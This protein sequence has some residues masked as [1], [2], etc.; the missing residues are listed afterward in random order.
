VQEVETVLRYHELSKHGSPGYAP[1]PGYLDW[2]NQ[3]DPFRR[4]HGAALLPLEQE[5][6]G[7][8]PLYE[9]AFLLG[10][11]P[12]SPVTLRSVSRLF[13][14]SLALSAWKQAGGSRW[15][16]RVNPSSGNLHP[17]EAYLVSGPIPGLLD[18]AAVCH[19]APREHALEVR[20]VLPEG[21]WE[22]I[23]A[24]LPPEALLVGLTS[25]HW[26]EAWKYGLRAYRYCQHDAGHALGAV[27]VAAAG[28][29]YEAR[30]LDGLGTA[31]IETLLGVTGHIGPESEEGDCLLAIVSAGSGPIREPTREAVAAFRG[32]AWRGTPNRLSPQHVDWGITGAAWAARKPPGHVPAEPPPDFPRL[33]VERSPLSLRRIIHQRRSAVAMDG[34]TGITAAAFYQILRKTLPGPDQVP[35]TTLP[36]AP[37][38]HLALFVHRVQGLDPG[39]YLLARDPAAVQSL[40]A[41]LP[42]DF[43]WVRPE[44]SPGAL[45]LFHLSTGDLRG[46]AS[47]LSCNQDIAGDGCFA[48]AMLAEFAGPVR[49]GAWWYPRLF[50]ECG[51][52]GQVLYLEAEASGISA[53]GIGCYF[54]DPTHAVLGLRDRTYQSLYHFT[55]GGRVDDPR[56]STLPAYENP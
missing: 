14:D 48:V 34:R 9:P 33:H 4:Y 20:A 27:A 31:R 40:R 1:G 26:R 29:G 12:P 24:G 36:W 32:L 8:E 15:A 50:W 54:D 23:A 11:E 39:L 56:L 49:Q 30:L 21:V 38:V 52:V 42:S 18:T 35:F 3:P 19:Y 44:G 47:R 53:T 22:S 16:L 5:H 7:E 45:P 10:S 28:L 55:L 43:Q 6:P 13:F 51:V 46:L 2:A 41:A 17:T 25:I 37:K